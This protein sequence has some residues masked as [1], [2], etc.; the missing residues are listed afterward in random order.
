[1]KMGSSKVI[2]ALAAA[3]WLLCTGPLQAQIYKTV[4]ENGNVTYSDKPM[5]DNAEPMTLPGLSVIQS[6]PSAPRPETDAASDDQQEVTSITELRRGYRDFSIV[7]PAPE[8]TIWG[9]ANEATIAWDSRYQLQPG[10]TVTFFVDGNALE[11]TTDA[12]MILRQLDRGAHTVSAELIDSRNRKI[13]TAETVTFY[14]QQYSVQRR[15]R[16]SRGG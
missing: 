13:A 10:M 16:N 9:T 14:I 1:M 5:D 8:E 7:S 6:V 2:T 15:A 4:D 12:S 3:G 11:P